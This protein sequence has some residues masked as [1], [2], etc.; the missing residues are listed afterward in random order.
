V[1]AHLVGFDLS[2]PQCPTAGPP[3]G[4]FGVVGIT[5]GRPFSANPCALREYRW[6]APLGTPS[7]YLNLAYSPQLGR[8]IIPTC[9]AAA[10]ARLTPLRLQRA[11]EIGCS[12]ASYAVHHAPGPTLR[13]WLDVEMANTWATR[14]LGA[15]RVLV[16]GA[17][18]FLLR[19][20]DRPVGVYSVPTH[21]RMITG[22]SAWFPLGVTADWLGAARGRTR[23]SAPR[24]CGIGFSGAPI[25]MVQYYASGPSGVYDADYAC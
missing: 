13:W 3:P 1:L 15:N 21:W 5:G 25:A 7:L 14:R 19:H 16:E 4:V 12:E 23:R 22:P 9:L 11:W 2:F 10:P 18:A 17:V 24:A 8:R 20:T 6:A